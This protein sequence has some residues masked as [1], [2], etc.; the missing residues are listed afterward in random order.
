MDARPKSRWYWN[1]LQGL[2]AAAIL[3]GLVWG[4]RVRARYLHELARLH[5]NAASR[6]NQEAKVA[7][8]LADAEPLDYEMAF[9]YVCNVLATLEPATIGD[10]SPT[11]QALQEQ[12]GRS[13]ATFQ[14]KTNSPRSM[15]QIQMI[16]RSE[17][18]EKLAEAHRDTAAAYRRAVWNPWLEIEEPPPGR[19]EGQTIAAKKQWLK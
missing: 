16:Q 1:A 7:R 6:L 18:L 10:N 13:G 19:G 12:M 15:Q 8:I 5:D 3:L 9:V 14:G 17:S 2:L 4:L 11:W